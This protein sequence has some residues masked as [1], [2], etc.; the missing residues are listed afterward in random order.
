MKLICF[1]QINIKLWYK[2]M[3]SVL[4]AMAKHAQSTQNNKFV[5]SLQYLKREVRAEVDFLLPD[6]Y[7]SF[8]LVDTIFGGCGQAYL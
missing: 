6:K 1:M 8:L 3:L 4:E 2:L 7:L 5:K